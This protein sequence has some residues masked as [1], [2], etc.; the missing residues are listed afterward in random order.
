M[1]RENHNRVNYIINEIERLEAIL[2]F[3][4]KSDRDREYGSAYSIKFNDKLTYS[5]PNNISFSMFDNILQSSIESDLEQYLKQ[6][7]EL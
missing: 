2:E 4:K 5:L 7:E 1:K 6:L 3:M